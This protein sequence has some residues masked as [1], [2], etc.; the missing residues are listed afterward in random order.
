MGIAILTIGSTKDRNF[1]Q[2]IWRSDDRSDLTPSASR[3]SITR[4][5]DQPITRSIK[6]VLP[7]LR[8][9]L[10]QQPHDVPAG[11]QVERPRLAD[12][13]HIGFHRKLI[14]FAAIASVAACNQ[15]FPGGQ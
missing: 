2:R 10:P 12:Q 8:V 5:P 4:P 14:A 11:V 6:Q 15:V 3:L 7:P 13:L 1:R 9:A